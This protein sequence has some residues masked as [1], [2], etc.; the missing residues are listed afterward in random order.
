[1]ARLLSTCLECILGRTADCPRLPI[2][3]PKTGSV[4]W[5]NP[6]PQTGLR[7]NQRRT[8]HQ[9]FTRVSRENDTAHRAH[10]VYQ[11]ISRQTLSRVP[12]VRFVSTGRQGEDPRWLGLHTAPSSPMAF[13]VV[14]L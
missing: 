8:G 13:K 2:Q 4:F 12:L 5:V 14:A 11:V 10:D 7:G 9:I 1:M 3:G 6:R